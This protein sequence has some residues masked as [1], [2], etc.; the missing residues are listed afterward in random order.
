MCKKVLQ[1]GAMVW[2]PQARAIHVWRSAVRLW[3]LCDRGAA[4]RTAELSGGVA[5]FHGLS[6]GAGFFVA[7]SVMVK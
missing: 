7:K 5:C 6:R 1:K 4:P 3:I 2:Y